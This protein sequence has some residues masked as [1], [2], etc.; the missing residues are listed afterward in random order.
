MKLYNYI[1]FLRVYLYAISCGPNMFYTIWDSKVQAQWRNFCGIFMVTPLEVLDHHSD[2]WYRN[3]NTC[4][5][6][7]DLTEEQEKL[8]IE[9]TCEM[10][11][12]ID[13]FD[14]YQKAE[15]RYYDACDSVNDSRLQE[16][17]DIAQDFCNE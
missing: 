4:K 12:M 17:F 16:L 5:R 8:F 2:Y 6:L 15:D 3:Y 11:D 1:D 14:D 10:S 13:A 7:F 9:L